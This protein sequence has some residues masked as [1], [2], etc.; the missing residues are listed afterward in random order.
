MEFVA[1]VVILLVAIRLQSYIFYKKALQKVDYKCEF[2]KTEASEGDEIYLVE[3]VHNKKLLPVPWLKVDINSSRW[4]DFANTRSVVAQENRYVTSSFLLKSYQKTIRRWKV[5]CLK[6]G[7]YTT[8]NVT[9]LSGDPLGISTN[10]IAVPANARITVYPATIDFERIFIQSKYLQGDTIIRRWIIDDPFMVAGAR[11][12]TPWDPMNKIHWSSTAR[13]GKLMVKKNDFTAQP[14]LTVV[15]NIQSIENEYHGT[16]DKDIIELGIKVA[17]TMFDRALKNGIPVR[18][19]SNGS[20]SSIPDSMIVTPMA[21]GREHVRALMGMLAQLELKRNKDFEEFL[22]IIEEEIKNT[23]III[24]T[25][26]MNANLYDRVYKLR[27]GRNSVKIVSLRKMES[28]NIMRDIDIYYPA[29][30]DY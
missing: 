18:F 13:A 15:L 5:K 28:K 27:S 17:A 6:R 14:E 11:E 8:K 10:S 3:T 12:Y 4:L 21:G 30:V 7:I 29:G 2:S 9:L 23:D 1:M 22:D 25:A 26:Y 24:I 20:L 16:V 19:A